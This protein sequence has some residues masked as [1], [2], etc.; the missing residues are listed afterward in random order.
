MI[1]YDLADEGRMGKNTV[2]PVDG[3]GERSS[4]QRPPYAALTVSEVN[5]EVLHPNRRITNRHDA[6]LSDQE[7]KVLSC[8]SPPQRTG[9][10]MH[11]SKN[12]RKLRWETL[13][14]HILRTC[15]QAR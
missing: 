5:R 12:T 14:T 8:S 11:E 13:P 15:C 1:R 7:R 9:L 3:I 4:L 2:A 10:M 6:L